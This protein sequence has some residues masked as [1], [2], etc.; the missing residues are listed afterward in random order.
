MI[1][2]AIRQRAS[3]ADVLLKAPQLMDALQNDFRTDMDLND[4]KA[5][6]D[7]GI[8]LPDS[9]I[10]RMGISDQDLVDDFAP[11]QRGSCG[12]PDAF[13]LCP[14]DP[15]YKTWHTI[16][17]H[18]F[19][20]PRT[21]DEHAPIQLVNASSISSDLQL[22]VGRI[23]APLGLGVSDGGQAPVAAQTVIYDHS[24][25]KDSQTAAWLEGFF[26]ASVV[27]APPPS[28][29]PAAAQGLVVVI[30]NDYARRWYGLA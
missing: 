28:G 29:A 25:G 6:Y 11:Y 16:F 24:G 18:A 12:A 17:A 1:V 14:E 15:T 30:G 19:V 10:E 21:V 23:L 7:F 20:D 4:L 8:K 22:R 26:G 27:Q 3:S 13:V 9:Y 5:L 2:S